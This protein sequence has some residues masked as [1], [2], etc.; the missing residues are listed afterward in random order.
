VL[1]PWLLLLL[2]LLLWGCK[3]SSCGC[4]STPTALLQALPFQQ[5][6]CHARVHHTPLLLS[7]WQWGLGALL[8]L[9]PLLLLLLLQPRE[10]W[11]QE[12]LGLVLRLPPPSSFLRWVLQLLLLLLLLGLGNRRLLQQG[13]RGRPEAARARALK[14]L[15]ARG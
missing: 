13:E 11:R 9:L 6:L 2:L 14:L 4:P 1:L 10:G 3:G 15:Q 8:L 12:E 7:R 5:L